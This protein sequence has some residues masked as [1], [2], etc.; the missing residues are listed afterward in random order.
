MSYSMGK[1]S[2]S[3]T[4]MEGTCGASPF[5]ARASDSSSRARLAFPLRLPRAHTRQSFRR[6]SDE[7]LHSTLYCCLRCKM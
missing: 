4:C 6:A 7:R 5:A 2:W 3:P 1:A